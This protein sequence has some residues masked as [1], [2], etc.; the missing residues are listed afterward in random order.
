MRSSDADVKQHN[1][2]KARKNNKTLYVHL[3]SIDNQEFQNWRHFSSMGS[4]DLHKEREIDL[5]IDDLTNEEVEH[6]K[7]FL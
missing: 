6:F 3:E 5:Y 4:F 2:Y 7:N 1:Y